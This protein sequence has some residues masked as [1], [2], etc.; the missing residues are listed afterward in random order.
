MISLDAEQIDESPMYARIQAQWLDSLL[1][2]DPRPWTIVTLH[3]P[4]YSTNPK[5]DNPRL[6]EL[7]KPIIDK[8]RVDLVLQ[9]HDHA[10]GRGSVANDPMAESNR[11]RKSETVYVVS[12]S[13]PKMYE[14]SDDPWMERRGQYL[15]LFQRIS[16]KDKRLTYEAFSADGQLYDSFQLDKGKDGINKLTNKIPE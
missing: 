9:G 10:Y 14:V 13:G 6:R 8:H 11:H 16:L 15:Q 12:V 5:R 2:N 4:F 3:Y 1:T 7:F